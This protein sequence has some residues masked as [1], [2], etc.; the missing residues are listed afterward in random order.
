MD[1]PLRVRVH[2]K[3]PYAPWVYFLTKYMGIWPKDSREK[4]GDDHFKLKP[5]GVG[6][7]PGMFEE[8]RPN[9]YVSLVRNPNYWQKDKPHWERLGRQDRAGGCDARCLPDDRD[10]QTSSP[11]RHRATSRACASRKD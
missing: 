5:V 7:G 6:T 10:R 4:L 2:L 1:S 8:W 3:E 11:R 9:E